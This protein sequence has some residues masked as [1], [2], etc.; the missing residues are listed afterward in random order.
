MREGFSGGAGK[1]VRGAL[2]SAIALRSL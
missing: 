2:R 1:P